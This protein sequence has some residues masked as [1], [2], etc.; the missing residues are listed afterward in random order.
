MKRF[1]L[2]AFLLC[3]ALGQAQ[4]HPLFTQYFFNDFFVNPA[5]AGSRDWYDVRS[6][7]RY[8][9]VGLTDA[10]RTFTLSACGPNKKDNMGFGGSVFTDNVGPTRRTGFNLSYA[11]HLKINDEIKLGLG[12]S[13]GML[14]FMIDGHKITT[15]DPGDAVISNGLQWSMEFDAQFGFYL[16]HKKWYVG[17]VIPQLLRNKLYFF[18]NQLT[19]GSNLLYHYNLTAGYK[20][21]LTD[22]LQLEPTFMVK[23]V[24]PIPVQLDLMARF[25]YKD[26]VWL[27]GSYRTMD[28]FTVM[29]GYQY[30]NYLSIGYSYDMTT[31][32]I[33]NYS[34]GTHELMLGIRFVKRHKE[35]KSK[36]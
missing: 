4:H 31:S 17:A 25:I 9:W 3:S 33:R 13:A 20:F 7:H 28:A 15:H 22:D 11:Y 6:N 1:F 35:S 8:Q 26:Q 2:I 29:A 5:V 23:Y 16:Y 27:G 30:K 14:Q 34:S 24:K 12:V 18:T 10:P 19:T 36:L 21:D 32:N